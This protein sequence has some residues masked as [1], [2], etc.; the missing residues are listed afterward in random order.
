MQKTRNSA[1]NVVRVFDLPREPF[2]KWFIRP[3]RA[4]GVSLPVSRHTFTDVTGKLTHSARQRFFEQFGL[5]GPW[6][7]EL[8][9]QVACRHNIEFLEVDVFPGGCDDI[10]GRECANFGFEVGVILHIAIRKCCGR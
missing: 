9:L 1:T 6:A 7:A 2:F 5:R 3:R 4:E 8:L 10:V